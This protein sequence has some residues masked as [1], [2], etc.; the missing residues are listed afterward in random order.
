MLR[1]NCRLS[2]TTLLTQSAQRFA[3]VCKRSDG[4][5]GDPSCFIFGGQ[6][7]G[8][9]P[10]LANPSGKSKAFAI[11][12]QLSIKGSLK[13]PL[14]LVVEDL[15]WVDKISEEFL[16]FLAE[17]APDTRTLLLGTYRPGYRPP[18]SETSHA[19]QASVQPLSRDDSLQMV[20]SVLSAE[21][22]VDSVTEEIVSK[23]DGNPLFLEQLTL[24]AGE[25][26]RSALMVP[27]TIYDVVMA[28]IDRLPDETKQLL[29]TAAVIGREFS[30]R[31]VSAVW[32]GSEPLEAHLRELVRLEFIS[33]HV[34][35]EGSTYVFRHWLTQE[36]AYGSLLGRHRR[37]YHG[38]VGRAL[39]KVYSGRTEEVAEL[40]ALHFGRSERPKRL[41]IMRYW[42][43]AGNS[44]LSYFSDALRR[45][46][47]L[48][49]SES[50]RLRRIRGRS[51]RA[52]ARADGTPNMSQR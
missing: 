34:E 8:D 48:T 21:S 33:E 44:R 42:P 14:V 25:N 20:R 32:K 52:Q 50:N 29:Q 38:A 2:R 28:R 49:D 4:P 7:L 12:R 36:T 10:A 11:L 16:G 26:L 3:R 35:T 46:W 24:H 1:S 5:G 27:N 30:S 23:A 45:L 19:A 17:S 18:W 13:R 31:L 43:W 51:R 22:L 47:R 15:H 6:E 9:Q 41:S 37:A 40:L 39:E